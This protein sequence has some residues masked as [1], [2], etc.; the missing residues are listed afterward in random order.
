M[1]TPEKLEEKFWLALKEDMTVMLG[2]NGIEENHARP[3]TAQF[4]GRSGPVWFFS[5][6]DT[7]IVQNIGSG[8]PAFFTFASKGNSL[9]ATVHGTIRV[10]HNPAVI[11]RLWSRFIAAWFEKG[12]EDP[13]LALLRFDTERAEIWEDEW[14]VVAGIKL[15]MGVDPKKDYRD[16]VAEVSL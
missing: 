3:M 14:S 1:T 9:F 5:S 16:K 15:L 4:E 12:K 8:Q 2:L 7:A 11:D 10:D 13:K 6:K